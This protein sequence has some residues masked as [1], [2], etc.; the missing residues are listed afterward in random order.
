MIG[1]SCGTATNKY[2]SQITHK[3]GEH[4]PGRYGSFTG[5]YFEELNLKS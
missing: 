2:T 5:D 4:K 1:G 3:K